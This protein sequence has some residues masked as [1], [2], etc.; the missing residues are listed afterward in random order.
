MGWVLQKHLKCPPFDERTWRT[1]IDNT[2]E[3]VKHGLAY[4][5]PE[6]EGVREKVAQFLA[7]PMGKLFPG[8]N[9]DEYFANYEPERI[10]IWASQEVIESNWSG[11]ALRLSSL[12]PFLCYKKR[13]T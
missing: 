6:L 12:K 8:E 13:Q 11:F 5:E 1:E 4:Y 9:F 3:F 10:A 7:T 2:E